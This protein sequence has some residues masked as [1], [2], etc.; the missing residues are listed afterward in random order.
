MTQE[1][2]LALIL[3]DIRNA[4]AA[5]DLPR[6]THW[7]EAARDVAIV[8]GYPVKANPPSEYI[9]AGRIE[10]ELPTGTVGWNIP[11]REPFESLTDAE[12]YQRCGAYYNAHIPD[13]GGSSQWP[14]PPIPPR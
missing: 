10:I 5:Q 4:E 13:Q 6:R 11:P 9:T 3:T 7:I 14:R 1:Q 12:N 8:L 2:N